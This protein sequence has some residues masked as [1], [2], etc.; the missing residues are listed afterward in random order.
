MIEWQLHQLYTM[1]A[2]YLL[3]APLFVKDLKYCLNYLS[4]IAVFSCILPQKYCLTTDISFFTLV[5]V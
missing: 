3:H 2:N 5:T 1:Y 4:Y